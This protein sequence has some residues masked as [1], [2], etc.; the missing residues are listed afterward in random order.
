MKQQDE[1][2]LLSD[3]QLILLAGEAAFGRGVAYFRQ[4]Q[5]LGWNK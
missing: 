2:A 3:R 5:V 4:G 1:A